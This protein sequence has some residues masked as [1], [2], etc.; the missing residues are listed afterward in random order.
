LQSAG[1]TEI[2]L[3]IGSA[4]RGHPDMGDNQRAEQITW[5]GPGGVQMSLFPEPGGSLQ[6]DLRDGAVT[7]TGKR[8][9]HLQGENAKRPKDVARQ[10]LEEVHLTIITS[11]CQ[12]TWKCTVAA[13]SKREA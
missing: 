11:H 7:I 2:S 4:E 5:D 3:K 10:V 12:I 8:C 6:V 9:R 13:E 1:H